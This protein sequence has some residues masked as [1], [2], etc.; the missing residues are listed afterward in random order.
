MTAFAR[1]CLLF[2]ASLA[3]IGPAIA[4]SGAK[5]PITALPELPA[6]GELTVSHRFAGIALNGFDPV[7]YFD[8]SRPVPG[9]R[10]HELQH[11]GATWRFA[12]EANREA[13]I[14]APD[15]YMPLFGG[16][17]PLAVAGGRAVAGLPQH[18]AIRS[19]R[20]LVFS[21]AEMRDR[22]V[23]S[24]DMLETAAGNWPAVESQLAR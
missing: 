4:T 16:Y 22:F 7:A 19:G 5:I 6:T 10:E 3:A 8:K 24:I 9:K 20:L 13:F 2:V 14:S 17:D 18:F 12:T 11:G 23:A 21:S 1:Q 15:A